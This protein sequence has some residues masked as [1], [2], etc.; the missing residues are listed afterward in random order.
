M[1]AWLIAITSIALS[2][3]AQFMLKGGMSSNRVQQVIRKSDLMELALC[4]FTDWRILLGFAL[5]GL[6]AL[7]W[8]GV[9]SKWDVSKAY[10]LV[11]IG[12]G[13]TALVG[14]AL[15]ESMSVAR[16]IGIALISTGVWIVART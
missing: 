2:V 7:L 11:G 14:F 16:G 1:K 10:P 12:F 8:L 13:F 6:G 3:T 15:G 9:L 4:I 5:Y